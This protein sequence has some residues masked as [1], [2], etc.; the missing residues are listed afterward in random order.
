VSTEADL[1]NNKTRGYLTHPYCNL[2][3]I[4]KHLETCFSKYVA[5]HVFE[6]TYNDFLGTNIGLKFPC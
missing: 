3:V 4:L 2:Y 1:L 5:F 6:D